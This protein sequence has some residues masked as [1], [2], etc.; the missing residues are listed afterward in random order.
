ME[1][2]IAPVVRRR[3][4]R[5]RQYDAVG[6][7]IYCNKKPPDVTLHL[8]HI[9]PESLGG[10]LTLPA[11]SCAGCGKETHA[12]EGQCAYRLF[13]AIRAQ[14]NFPSK[15]SQKNRMKKFTMAFDGVPHKIHQDDYP[16]M[17]LTFVHALPGILTDKDPAEDYS[18]GVHILTL[19]DFGER[20]NKL[21][22]SSR[23]ILA[24]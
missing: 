19:P 5:R 14:Y 20:L 16:G 17:V 10:T 6:E 22:G 8:E 4:E 18:G 7:C 11:S 13:G 9:I 23:L 24:T 1:Q 15:R 21:N 12:Y 3:M 2:E